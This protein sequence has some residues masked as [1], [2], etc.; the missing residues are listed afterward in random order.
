MSQAASYRQENPN[1]SHSVKSYTWNQLAM[2]NLSWFDQ[3]IKWD[4]A[5]E[6]YKKGNETPQ[7]EFMQKV[8]GETYDPSKGAQAYKPEK[9]LVDTEWDKE[10]YRDMK[11]D[12]QED[13]FWALVAAWAKDG[14]V[15]ILW[16][17]M[18]RTWG[19]VEAKQKE[20]KVLNM[21]VGCDSQYRTRE[22]YLECVKHGDNYIDNGEQR[23]FCW[24]AFR[25]EDRKNYPFVVSRGQ[26]N[27]RT[28][29][30]AYSW[31]PHQGDPMSGKA[32]GGQYFCP[33]IY[34]SNPTIKDIAAKIRDGR[35]QKLSIPEH[36]SDEL[37]KHLYSEKRIKVWD[38]FGQDS[39]RWENIGKRPNHLWDCFCMSI[40][41]ACIAGVIGEQTTNVA[42]E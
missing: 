34:W 14:E 37:M 21:N 33:L 40:V 29:E 2:E 32:E 10:F 25:G 23:F 19:D 38:K 22:V 15:R 5:R 17:G 36:C 27:Q 6:Q 9:I 11:V 30:L 7:R 31:P 42:R 4:F 24:K 12:V 41:G 35:A 13:H 26:S 39:W 8:L 18:L 20:F 28:I 1:A 3:F 16:S